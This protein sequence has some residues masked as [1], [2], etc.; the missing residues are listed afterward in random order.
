MFGRDEVALLSRKVTKLPVGVG[1]A[2]LVAEA[3]FDLQRF[4]IPS[5]CVLEVALLLGE[6]HCGPVDVGEEPFEDPRLGIED[7]HEVCGRR[8]F[9]KLRARVRP[10]LG[11]RAR[12]ALSLS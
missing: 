8:R 2:V 5:L 6:V 11:R 1:R 3:F 7:Q 9:N 4:L 12:L 10:R